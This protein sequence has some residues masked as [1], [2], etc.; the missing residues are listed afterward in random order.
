M[1]DLGTLGGTYSFAAGIND[2]GQVVGTSYTSSG[3]LRAFLI[4][5]EDTNGDGA[6]DRWFRDTNADGRND[7]MRDSGR[8]AARMPL[9]RPAM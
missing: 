5:P 1:T 6:P 2:A 9:R 3:A 8:W 4:T 7:L